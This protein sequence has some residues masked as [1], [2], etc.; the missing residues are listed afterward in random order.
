MKYSPFFYKTKKMKKIKL[1]KDHAGFK[2][3]EELQLQLR[4]ALIWINKG[5]AEEAKNKPSLTK[6]KAPKEIK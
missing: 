4:V 2:K 3:G 5:V 6:K 1:I